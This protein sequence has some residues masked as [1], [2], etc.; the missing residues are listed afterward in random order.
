MEESWPSNRT[1]DTDKAWYFLSV[2]FDYGPMDRWPLG[3][4]FRQ[5]KSLHRGD[6]FII[7]LIENS[8]MPALREALETVSRAE[9][10]AAYFELGEG[11]FRPGQ[12]TK[13]GDQ[14]E[15]IWQW[16]ARIVR[17]LKCQDNESVLFT[18]DFA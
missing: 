14:F 9:L 3:L 2:C 7:N 10:K 15:Y 18:S 6:C 12:Y 8:E 5:G 17:F 13:T 16:F 4:L 11:Y 1:Q